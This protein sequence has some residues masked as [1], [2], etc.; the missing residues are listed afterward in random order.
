MNYLVEYQRL[1]GLEPDG[2]IGPNT[3]RVM[4]TEFGIQSII[5]YCHFIAQIHHESGTFSH[6]R[7]DLHYRAE[8]LRKKFNKYFKPD[9]EYLF[10]FHEEE[11]ANRIYANRSGNGPEESGDGFKYRGG[12]GIQTTF[13]NNW[14]RLFNKLGLPSDTDPDDVV[15]PQYYFKAADIYFD[16]NNVWKYCVD[17]SPRSIMNVSKKINL[18]NVLINAMPNGYQ[19]RKEL[20]EMYYS[21]LKDVVI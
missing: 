11:I 8:T 4:C 19:E 9:E 13:K 10:A 1:K 3:A 12:M 5:Q 16:D 18:G 14:V 20:T 15:K 2:K 21:K 6:G 7:E 17:I